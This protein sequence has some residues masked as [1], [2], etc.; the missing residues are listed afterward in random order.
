MIGALH[1]LGVSEDAAALD[2][3]AKLAAVGLPVADRMDVDVQG[4]CHLGFLEA[5]ERQALRERCQDP[6]Q[7]DGF[8][9]DRGAQLRL[10]RN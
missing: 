2:G 1:N 4:I 5:E 3:L 7:A 8:I 9:P 10:E 6:G